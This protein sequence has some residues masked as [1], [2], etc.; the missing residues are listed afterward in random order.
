VSPDEHAAYEDAY[1]RASKMVRKGSAITH[2]V[3]Q[4]GHLTAFA[5]PISAPEPP[6]ERQLGRRSALQGE[7]L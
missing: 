7:L 5:A 1:A 3:W 6:L 4:D 2:V